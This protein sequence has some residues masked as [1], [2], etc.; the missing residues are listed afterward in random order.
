MFP[1]FPHS[2]SQSSTHCSPHLVVFL[3]LLYA[4]TQA[5]KKKHIKVVPS[6]QNGYLPSTK[7]ESGQ[8]HRMDHEKGGSEFTTWENLVAT[9]D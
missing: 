5:A 7:D 4:T 6:G 3:L 8:W 2:F 1:A 9:S